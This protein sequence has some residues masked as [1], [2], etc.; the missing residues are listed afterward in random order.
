MI[1]HVFQYE[2]EELID[3][4]LKAGLLKT[5][6]EGLIVDKPV[7][8]LPH[9]RMIA[10]AM[11]ESPSITV[12]EYLGNEPLWEK[13][14]EAMEFRNDK[15][16]SFKEAERRVVAFLREV[17]GYTPLSSETS[18]AT[19]GVEVAA[20]ATTEGDIEAPRATE[21]AESK[22]E[23]KE[24]FPSEEQAKNEVDMVIELKTESEEQ[25]TEAEATETQSHA[26]KVEE[27][28]A[29]HE[30][31][32][33][34]HT[35]EQPTEPETEVKTEEAATVTE[36]KSPEQEEPKS[37]QNQEVNQTEQDKPEGDDKAGEQ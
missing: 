23:V 32:T 27:E 28:A 9:L 14:V 1:S 8:Y 35:S 33:S 22:N 31:Q 29:P 12:Q 10:S 34:E 20:E 36:E 18:E 7:G 30:Q 4:L 13:Y 25:L 2:E 37:E 17:M 11:A 21:E 16:L 26:E 6:I 24:A 3:Q 15:D 5:I 19:E